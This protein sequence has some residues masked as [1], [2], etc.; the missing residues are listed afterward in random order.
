M[1]HD[2][3]EADERAWGGAREG[4]GRPKG[5]P[6]LKRA[7]QAVL[8]VEEKFPGW[9]PV[10]HL[11]AVANDERL[12]PVIRLDAAKAAAPYLHARPKPV[13]LDIDAV[14]ELE[15]RLIDAKINAAA[16]ASVTHPG[17][18]G[19][20]ERLQR[21]HERAGGVS[22][23]VETGV[24]RGIDDPIIDVTPQATQE[25]LHGA[26]SPSAGHAPAQAASAAPAPYVPIARRADPP[27]APATPWPDRPA[28]AAVDYSP[29]DDA[30][31][32]G[33]L[34]ASRNS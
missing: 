4:A 9:S 33:G 23:I 1:D 28:V 15:T 11:A 7:A 24:P 30:T 6:S 25:A 10:L 27:P 3:D 32:P 20:A 19:L 21:A 22:I 34:A 18:Y 31:Y 29:F 12:D 13:E 16:K 14:V 17:L 26:A 8:E 5:R 2:Q